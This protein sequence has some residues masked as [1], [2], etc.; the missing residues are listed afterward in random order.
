MPEIHCDWERIQRMSEFTGVTVV[1]GRGVPIM[2]L[3]FFYLAL[4]K[5]EA[6]TIGRRVG[7]NQQQQQRRI[8]FVTSVDPVRAA[9]VVAD[10]DPA[11]TMILSIALR[12]N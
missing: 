12:G 6:A 4:C 2:A 11:S 10:L 5:D 7:L 8:K 3:R 9:A 1:I